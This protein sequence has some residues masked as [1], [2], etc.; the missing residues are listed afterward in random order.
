M[1][2]KL[3][4]KFESQKKPVKLFL[5]IPDGIGIFVVV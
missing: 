1:G 2:N 3:E 4:K 5:L